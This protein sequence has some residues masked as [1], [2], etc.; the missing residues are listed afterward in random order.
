MTRKGKLVF[1]VVIIMA[2]LLKEEVYGILFHL[3]ITNKVDNYI[4]EIK[5]ENIEKLYNELVEAYKYD[6]NLNYELEHTKILFNNTYNLTDKITIYKGHKNNIKEK[7][8]VINEQGLVGI[9]NKVNKNSSEV[10][11]LT[12]KD[13]NLS[14]KINE[15]YGI[16]KY[17]NNELIVM[18]INN[19]GK[20]DIGDKV[21]TSDV[22]N[23]PENVLIG[24]VSNISVDNYE[25]E[26]V[27]KI[28][29]AVNFNN[30]KYLSV[31]TDLRG[32]E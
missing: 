29:P 16:L 4:C 7:N 8:L 1:I 25:I 20:L 11:L 10:V 19:K 13:L 14:V 30:L 6:D 22:S 24:F 26:K 5:N 9:V 28:T 27:L 15:N 21:Y 18:G 32:Q 31:I 3:N 12:N 2:I 17:E 23:Y